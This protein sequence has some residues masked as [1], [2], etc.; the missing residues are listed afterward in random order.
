M[1]ASGTDRVENVPNAGGRR[2]ASLMIRTAIGVKR[3]KKSGTMIQ[4]KEM[5]TT[6]KEIYCSTTKR[7]GG[8]CLKVDLG[9]DIHKELSLWRKGCQ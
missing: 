6:G 1:S 2:R 8:H 7:M 4:T 5:E 3:T 9:T